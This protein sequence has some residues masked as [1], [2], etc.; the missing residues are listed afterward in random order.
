VTFGHRLSAPEQIDARLAA[1]FERRHAFERCLADADVKMHLS[2]H[3]SQGGSAAFATCPCCG[4]P[5]LRERGHFEICEICHWEDDGQD[6]P[7]FAPRPDVSSPD[8]IT[9]GPNSYYSLTE[10]RL[11][12]ELHQQM[13]RAAD[14]QAFEG[15]NEDRDLRI[16]FIDVFDK[17]LPIV[18][19]AS[20]MQSVV[21]F[22]TISKAISGDL[23]ARI[24]ASNSN[25]RLPTNEGTQ[26]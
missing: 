12:F 5:T 10:A 14:K 18:S 22:E 9:G 13:Y 3:V 25:R 7:D 8:V 21:H 16:S 17:L 1:F 23:S 26:L 20:Y 24:S 6:D 2:A 15:T 19:P 4:Y 11:N